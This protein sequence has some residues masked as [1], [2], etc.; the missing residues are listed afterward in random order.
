MTERPI[1]FSR[2]SRL[3]CL[4]SVWSALPSSRWRAP[5]SVSAPNVQVMDGLTIPGGHSLITPP[6]PACRSGDLH[7]D[8]QKSSPEKMSSTQSFFH[9]LQLYCMSG[10]SL[11]ANVEILGCKADMSSLLREMTVG[12][13]RGS[14]PNYQRFLLAS[15]SHPLPTLTGEAGSGLASPSSGGTLL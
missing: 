15:T 2:T 4:D 5:A 9:G 11:T 12:V 6:A 10:T 3:P 13:W 7:E 14:F 1:L 8:D